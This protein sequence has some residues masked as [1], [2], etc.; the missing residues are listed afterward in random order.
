MKTL[1]LF[2]IVAL[3][4]MPIAAKF[5]AKPKKEYVAHFEVEF[6]LPEQPLAPLQEETT[7]L[8]GRHCVDCSAGMYALR[9]DGLKR[10]S[11]CGNPDPE[12]R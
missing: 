3:G 11:A 7:S 1:A 4:L 10:C 6:E 9:D 12:Q 8:F 2:S 5:V